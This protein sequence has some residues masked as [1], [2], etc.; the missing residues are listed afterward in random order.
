MEHAKQLLS[1]NLGAVPFSPFRGRLRQLHAS[2]LTD[3]FDLFF[4]RFRTE[5][6]VGSF[7][8]RGGG[9]AF[10]GANVAVATDAA[11]FV[12]R[13]RE[14]RFSGDDSL[15]RKRYFCLEDSDTN[16]P[17]NNTLIC[18]LFAYADPRFPLL[19]VLLDTT[20]D[21]EPA[22]RLCRA[23]GW[24][25][26]EPAILQIVRSREDAWLLS[27]V[28]GISPQGG[29]LRYP[30][31]V[32]DTV[33][34]KAIDLRRP[35]T[36]RWF[37][38]VFI[39]LEVLGEGK[40]LDEQGSVHVFSKGDPPTDIEGALRTILAQTLGGG[41]T[42]IQ[43]IGACLRHIGAEALIYP[44]ARADSRSVVRGEAIEESYGYV[45]VD[46]RGAPPL[47]FDPHR[48]FGAL[49]RW[50]DR[51]ARSISVR[52]ERN[53]E[54]TRLSVTGARQL[55]QFRYAVF[56]DWTVNSLG[57]ARSDLH[58][59]NTTLGDPVQLA[60]RRPS[61]IVGPE[62][63]QVLGQDS[64]FFIEERGPVT[65]FLVEWVLGPSNTVASFIGSLL[66]VAQSEFWEDRWR[67][68]GASWFLYRSC[69]LRPWA[70]LK[71]PVCFS[72]FFWDVTAGTPLAACASCSFR[73]DG[74]SGDAL[75]RHARW[76]AQ[77]DAGHGGGDHAPDD[78]ELDNRIYAAACEGHPDAITGMT[79]S[80][81]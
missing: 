65:G 51:L 52:H 7:V 62:A 25:P 13:G 54:E 4:P 10:A 38:D 29:V 19:P 66:P 58:Q 77:F 70:I 5:S 60:L 63:N 80:T 22:E 37:F 31:T 55:Q 47:D 76:A 23:M 30:L 79:R 26:G 49:P 78:R 67:W 46:Y 14:R 61:Q 21:R 18:E 56:H 69:R 44:S 15:P 39:S 73:Q 81:G 11:A 16:D 28:L 24:D 12:G 40:F 64:E 32:L 8:T 3:V 45:L 53:A 75:E 2:E 74:A 34:E 42:F 71:C 33:I 17:A 36:L 27:P 1:A 48:Y 9:R 43:G 20:V 72:E 68:D 50:S 59:R 57:R 41:T 35:E 6:A